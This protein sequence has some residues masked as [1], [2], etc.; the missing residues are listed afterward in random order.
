MKQLLTFPSLTKLQI[1]WTSAA[2]APSPQLFAA[3]QLR[4]LWRRLRELK[5][6]A[7]H[8]APSAAP[9][10]GADGQSPPAR[11]PLHLPDGLHHLTSL[12]VEGLIELRASV[13]PRG[14]DQRSFAALVLLELKSVSFQNRAALSEIGAIR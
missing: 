7:P 1:R 11:S 8:E 10:P 5:L 13:M 9:P 4:P 2:S 6:T 14:L 3:H 12:Y